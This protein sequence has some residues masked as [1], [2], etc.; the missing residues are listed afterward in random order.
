MLKWSGWDVQVT[1]PLIIFANI[2]HEYI[3]CLNLAGF[4]VRDKP[5][6][7]EVTVIT[8]KYFGKTVTYFMPLVFFYTPWKHQ[9]TFGLLMFSM[10]IEQ[11]QSHEMG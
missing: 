6:E 1:S 8:C 11:N 4:L 5:L 2:S 10:G 3:V 7:F 9:E